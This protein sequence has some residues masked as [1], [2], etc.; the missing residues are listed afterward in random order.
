MI[1]KTNRLTC[2]YKLAGT[3][4][5][6]LASSKLLGFFGTNLQN[7]SASLMRCIIPDDDMV[8]CQPDQSGAEALVVAYEAPAGKFRKLFELNIKVHSYMALQLFIDRFKGE[9]PKER[10]KFID[11]SI[12]A[13]YP[14][15]PTL[16]K[17]IKNS[18]I[19]YDL[20]KRIIHAKNY[21]MKFRTFQL[22]TL[23]MSE[24]Q[25]VLSAKDAK[26]FLGL[27]EQIFP[28]I[29][30]LLLNIKNRL[31]A[32]RT[33]YNLFGYPRH[34]GGVWSDNLLRDAYAFIPQSTVGTITNLAFIELH[35]YIVDNNLPWYLLNNKHDS[36][37]L[38]IPD[39]I[40]HKDM[41]RVAVK[42][43]M[44]RELVS[45]TGEHY[46]MKSGISW[47]HNWSKY[48][49]NINPSGMKEE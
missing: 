32:T 47:G 35:H 36:L 2:G 10:Y 15:L 49:T 28:E 6:R 45:T 21:D 4:N 26:D 44:E 18:G 29:Q 7:P 31:L 9:H 24:G 13:T 25:I 23:D 8:F 37:L 34:F 17:Q 16:L 27:H 19:P 14:E 42:K 30:E 11:P 46:Q 48:D 33:L 1:T 5:F 38:Q 3:K 40:E 12:L 41:C 20:G 22:N 39:T 43:A